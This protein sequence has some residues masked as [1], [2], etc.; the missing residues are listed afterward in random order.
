MFL[1]RKGKLKVDLGE[2][3]DERESLSNFLRLKLKVDVTTSGNKVLVD[4]E[5]LSSKELERLVDRFVY[6][7]NL[8]NKYW[9]ALE[10]GV[11][12]I[13]KVKRSKKNEK[14]K[15]KGT[16][17]RVARGGW[18]ISRTFLVALWIMM[19]VASLSLI[20]AFLSTFFQ[21]SSV[22][23]L[24]S[25]DWGGYVVVS[26][27]ANPQ[28]VVVGVSGSWTVPRVNISQKDTF[29]A[30]WIG[31][32][33]YIDETLIQIGTEHDSINSSAVYST[34]YELLPHY[35]DTITTMN[36]SPGDKITASTNLVDSTKNEWSIEIA[37]VTKGQRFKQNFFY[38]SSRLS[39]EWIVERPTV[40]NSLSSLADFGSITF[41]DLSSTLNTNVGPISDFPFAQV[42]IHDRQ[43]RELV[44]VSSL[45]SNGSS[46]TVKYLSSV[47]SLQTKNAQIEAL[48][49]VVAEN[50][51][52]KFKLEH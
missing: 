18:R 15:K 36:V 5:N 23:R 35:S 9:V 28:P 17:A 50:V 8:M 49:P 46:F 44:T 3:K 45:I 34:W 12:K 47:T 41:T 10:S 31:I 43:N 22:R 52:R 1:R 37:D 14:R 42:I 33:G 13:N 21:S 32:G 19:L 4:S 38:N 51:R 29:S 6:H 27:F 2:L 7:R 20:T 30:A 26:D 11:V 16:R 48:R 24:I 39:A 25:L 40:N